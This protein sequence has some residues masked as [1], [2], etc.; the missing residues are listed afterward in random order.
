MRILIVDDDYV[1]R[2]KLSALLAAYGQC[3]AVPNGEIALKMFQEAHKELVPYELV[4][5]DVEMPEISG[6]DVV[7]QMRDIERALQIPGG[8][9]VKVLM[10]TVKKELKEVSTAYKHG[11]TGYITKPVTPENLK[12]AVAD[13]GIA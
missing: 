1:S 7:G 2:T 6:H 4:T 3:D 5:M 12:K 9:E 11:C 8:S 13:I 10:V